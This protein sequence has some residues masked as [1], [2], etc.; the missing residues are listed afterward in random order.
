[1][2]N[3]H[4]TSRWFSWENNLEP[5]I[6]VISDAALFGSISNRILTSIRAIEG[7]M[8]IYDSGNIIGIVF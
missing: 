8:R 3:V 7:S 6:M 1:M 5:L 2:L 4:L